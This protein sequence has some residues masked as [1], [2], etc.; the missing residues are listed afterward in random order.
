MPT[1]AAIASIIEA[2][3]D[4]GLP[5][6]IIRKARDIAE[7]SAANLRRAR[8]AGARFAGGSDAG[9]PFNGHHNYAREIELMHTTL[10]MTPRESLRAAT[11]HAAD[12]IGLPRGTL[13]PG[14][15][16]DL[17]CLPHDIDHDLTALRAPTLVVKDGAIV[18]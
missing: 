12:L 1:L 18:R 11:V 3:P 9:T 6:E 15:V 10:A 13:N 8:T 16:A 7:H 17:V 14:D 4:A 2:T 5:T